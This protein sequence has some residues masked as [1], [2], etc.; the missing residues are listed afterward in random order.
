MAKQ[1]PAESG[2]TVEDVRS[3]WPKVLRAVQGR[4]K[5]LA[6]LMANVQVAALAGDTLH[7][8]VA[9]PALR[10]RFFD[11]QHAQTLRDSVREVFQ[12]QWEVIVGEGA[13]AA[14]SST[15]RAVAEPPRKAAPTFE[16]RSRGAQ[17][18]PDQRQQ[19]ARPGHGQDQT[20]REQPRPQGGTPPGGHHDDIPLPP[21]PEPEPEPEISEEQMMAD[22]A[23][24]DAAVGESSAPR[25]DP[26]EVALELL[27]S[28]LG[29]RPID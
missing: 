7:V 6:T 9:N 3:D 2:I 28:E 5:V 20:P 23:A 21:E 24:E 1:P 27:K 16:R 14:P 26:D 17:Q 15:P 18:T 10:S 29:A 25:R 8:A 13:P 22:A 19:F 11:A 12:T 4:S